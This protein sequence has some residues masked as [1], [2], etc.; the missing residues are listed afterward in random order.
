VVV[1]H[2]GY[3]TITVMVGHIEQLAAASMRVIAIDSR[4]HGK[5][6]D[7]GPETTYEMMS[8]DVIAVMDA[9][10]IERTAVVGWSDGGNVGLDLARRYGARITK[11]VAFGANHTP[12]TESGDAA[13]VQRFEAL[14]AD[15]PLVW[16]MRILYKKSSPTP[17]K[18]PEFFAREQRLILTQPNWSLTELRAITAPVLLVNGEHDVVS[19][20][21][22]TEM[23]DAIR[24]ARLEIIRG[25]GHMFPLANPVVV[26]PLMLA[27]LV[28]DS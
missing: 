15:S 9:L 21:Y 11:V 18:W 7:T 13:D 22:A 2:G 25:E 5:S 26:K 3:G 19:L 6:T 8:D 12:A 20:A 16:P 1:L 14:H 28:S 27:F 10:G 23:K 4:G 17:E 24:G